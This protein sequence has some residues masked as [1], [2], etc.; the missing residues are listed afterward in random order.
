MKPRHKI[1]DMIKTGETSLNSSVIGIIEGVLI[2]NN[3]IEYVMGDESRIKEE[4]IV[5][6]YKEVKPRAPRKAKK[7]KDVAAEPKKAKAA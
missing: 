1:G 6:S 7:T 4:D 3:S 5:A 2:K